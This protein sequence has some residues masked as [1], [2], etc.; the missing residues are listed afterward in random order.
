MEGV[1]RRSPGLASLPLQLRQASHGVEVRTREYEAEA[2]RQK[3]QARLPEVDVWTREAFSRRARLYW[4]NQTGSGGALLLTGLL[5][6][7]V[8]LVIVSQTIYSTTMDNLEEF[9]TLKAIGA[10]RRYVQCIVL[11]QSL[12]CGVIGSTIGLA[13][14]LPLLHVVRRN[15]SWVYTPWWLP[16]GMIAVSLLM[17][18]SASIVSIRKA[19]SVEPA[20]VFRA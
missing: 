3:L 4:V 17:C 19:V 1:S 15:I 14:I 7:L 5:G 13:M 18:A 16:V 11:T 6:F 20:R 10:S 8:G 12:V 2:V 9:A